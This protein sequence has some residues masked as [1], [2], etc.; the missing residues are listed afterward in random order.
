MSGAIW[1][2]RTVEP[3]GR[4]LTPQFVRAV[5]VTF[6]A[7]LTIGMLLPVLPLFA[8][9]PLGEGSVGVG[10]AVA[11]ASPTAFLF[12]PLAGR[13]GDRRGR[14]LLVLSGPLVMAASVAALTVANDLVTLSLLRLVSGAGEALVLVGVATMINDLAP[15]DRRGEAVSLYSLG[16]WGGLAVGPVLGELVLDGDRYDA[17]WLAAAGCALLAAC[18]AVTLPETRPDSEVDATRPN[19]LVHPAAVG[20]GLILV[21]TSFAFAGFNAFVSLYARDLGLGGAGKVFFLYSVVVVGIRVFGRRLPDRLGPKR[22]AG[23]ALAATSAGLLV[24]GFW[25]QPLGLYAGTAVF[26]VGTALLFPALMTLAVA[27]AAPAERSSV[28]GT[29]TAFFDVGFALGALTQGGVASVA[30]YEGVFLA[31]AFSAL[32][33]AFMLARIPPRPRLA[34]ARA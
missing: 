3:S 21:F 30:G 31:G 4:L 14:R 22:A 19:R 16:V 12:Q 20:P 25:N 2:T 5:L 1:L 33:G 23:A 11:A 6:G 13:L 28:I 18:I 24:I 17:V 32:G 10:V 34:T 26:A 9:G 7:F 8:K 27:G 29:F 15:D